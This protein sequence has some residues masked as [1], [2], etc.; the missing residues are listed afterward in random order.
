MIARCTLILE[1]IN[2][3]NSVKLKMLIL[4]QLSS[5]VGHCMGLGRGGL[6]GKKIY[7]ISIS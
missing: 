1:E 7:T 2:V 4:E 5:A 6:L 3:F